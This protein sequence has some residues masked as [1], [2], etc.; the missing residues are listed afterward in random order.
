MTVKHHVGV[1]NPPEQHLKCLNTFDCLA[2]EA[3]QRVL[4][5]VCVATFLVTIVADSRSVPTVLIPEKWQP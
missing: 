5:L 4:L 3:T 1:E 2:H